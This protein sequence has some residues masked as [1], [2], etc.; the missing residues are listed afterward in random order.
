MTETHMPKD[1][2]LDHTL[3]LLDEGYRFVTNRSDKFESRVFETRLLGEKTICMVGEKEAELFMIM[4]NFLE[5]MLLPGEFRK[6]C[7]VREAFRD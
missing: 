3:K 1:K 7:L 4:P 2:G 5:R 6:R